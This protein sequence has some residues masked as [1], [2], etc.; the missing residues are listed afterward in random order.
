[1][2]VCPGRPAFRVPVASADG[3]GV[4]ARLLVLLLPLW[5][6]AC[7]EMEATITI[8]GDGSGTQKVCLG[9]SPQVLAECKRAA[10]VL[11]SGDAG[12]PA[13]VF[14]KAAVEKELLGTGLELRAH[15]TFERGAQRWVELELAFADL[16][17]LRKSPLCG[18]A[19]LWEFTGGPLPGTIQVTLYP[20]GKEAWTKARQQA[21]QWQTE[22]DPTVAGF[23]ARRKE[24]LRGLDLAIHFELPGKVL[25]MTRNLEQ[26]GERQVTARIKAEQI[27]TPADL[28]RRLAPRFEVVIEGQG[29][30]LPL[31]GTR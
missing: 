31:D 8:R 16:A 11:A 6:V 14:E 15:R 23:F 30:T 3:R 29:C 21:E 24:Q 25:R 9:M 20:Q 4:K 13:H 12:N 5:S 19:P 1:M 17:G 7:L 26:T 27:E 22:A 2:A 28:V 10:A 18:S